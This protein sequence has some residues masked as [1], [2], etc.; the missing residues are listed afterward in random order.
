MRISGVWTECVQCFIHKSFYSSICCCWVWCM[1]LICTCKILSIE[2]VG[3]IAIQYC[4]CCLCCIGLWCA[5]T[6]SCVA[7]LSIW[8]NCRCY[9]NR[10]LTLIFHRKSKDLSVIQCVRLA[11]EIPKRYIQQEVVCASYIGWW[12]L[13]IDYPI[14]LVKCNKAW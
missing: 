6:Y 2:F 1:G 9:V 14:C 10:I 11:I 7:D 3:S 5:T 4:I 13:Y 12:W 8:Q